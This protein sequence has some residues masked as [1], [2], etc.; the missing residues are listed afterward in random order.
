MADV[1][2]SLADLLALIA[3]LK[4]NVLHIYHDRNVRELPLYVTRVELELETRGPAHVRELERA[5]TNAGYAFKL[6]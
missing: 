5:L 4:A 3:G 6:R 1:P 2:G